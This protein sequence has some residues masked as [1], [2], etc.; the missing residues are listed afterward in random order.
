MDLDPASGPTSLES[1]SGPEQGMGVDNS[2]LFRLSLTSLV[3]VFLVRIFLLAEKTIA[4]P[5]ASNNFDFR[6]DGLFGWP[7]ESKCIRYKIHQSSLDLSSSWA[8][9]NVL[10]GT[11]L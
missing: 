11:K 2:E 9:G 8:S 7:A 5:D 6:K 10:D 3:L 4:F 1:Q